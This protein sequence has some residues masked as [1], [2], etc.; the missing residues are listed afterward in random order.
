[1]FAARQHGTVLRFNCN[2][3]KISFPIL[4]NV[5]DAG[6]STTCAD[7]E[8][9]DIDNAICVTPDLLCRRSPVDFGVC[10]MAELPGHH[11][12][13]GCSDDLLGLFDR[14]SDPFFTWCKYQL[15]TK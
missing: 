3:S 5:T 8:Y 6:E 7:A 14:A 13:I 10:R 11:G 4:Q 2:D 12:L 9:E 1:M 15:C